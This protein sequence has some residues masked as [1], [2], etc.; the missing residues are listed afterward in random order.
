MDRVHSGVAHGV[1]EDV[2][3]QLTDPIKSM[4]QSPRET[5]SRSAIQEIPYLLWNPKV[6]YRVC[7][8]PPPVPILSQINPV[9]TLPPYFLK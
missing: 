7:K 5:D 4:Q 1:H 6:H 2:S 3:V 8:S 9:N